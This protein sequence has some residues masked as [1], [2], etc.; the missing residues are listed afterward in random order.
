[1]SVLPPLDVAA[2]ANFSFR[3]LCE[4]GETWR[5]LRLDNY[6]CEAATYDAMQ[7]LCEQLLDPIIER[8]GW[9]E[10]TYGFAGSQLS[11]AIRTGIAPRLD[12]HAGHELRRD[13]RPICPR[14]GQAVDFRPMSARA[15]EV[16]RYIA[17][18]LPFDR[19][20]LYG[21][22]RPLHVSIGPEQAG[23]VLFVDRSH[24]RPMPRRVDPA[25]LRTGLYPPC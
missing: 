11:R 12:Q 14:L 16:A 2:G 19:L 18:E 5:S 21:P 25:Q 20:Y 17:L 24:T 15:P 23:A 1:V 8:F 13:G 10:L 3:D 9:I 4:C 6:P 22:D 7:R